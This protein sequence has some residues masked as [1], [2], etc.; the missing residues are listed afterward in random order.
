[1]RYIILFDSGFSSLSGQ[2][3]TGYRCHTCL[4]N[5]ALVLSDGLPR[6]VR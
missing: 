4:N 2:L 6:K 3:G 5:F 1:L